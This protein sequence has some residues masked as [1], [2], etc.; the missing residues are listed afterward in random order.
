MLNP[1][2]FGG[3]IR[4]KDLNKFQ[5]SK[6]WN[7]K[8]FVNLAATQIDINLKTLPTVLKDNFSGKQDRVPKQSLPIHPF[9]A[10][11]FQPEDGKPKFIWY[12]HSVVLMQLHGFNLLIDPMFGPDASPIGPFATKRFSN[13]TL[14]I[15]DTLP[16]IDAILLTHDHYDHLDYKSI[17]KLKPKVNIWLVALGIS[18]H[19]EKWEIPAQQVKEFDWW[20]AVEFQGIKLTFTPSRH[21]A[22]RGA[23]DRS[24]TLWGG[25][26]FQSNDHKI[27]WSGDGG[28]GNHFKA[29]GQEY[30]P[31]DLAFVECG[32][33]YKHW[34][35][36]HLYPEESI[37]AAMDAQAQ[38]AVPVHWGAFTL[39]PHHWKDP[40]ERFVKEAIA[41]K[42]DY[43][44]PELGKI[45]T[46]ETLND[47]DNWWEKIK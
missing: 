47:M 6:N 32:Q 15:I 18:R 42:Q 26:I 1:A 46:F 30:G 28:Y 7:G 27:Y 43:F 22:G 20:E 34:H 35:Q 44:I 37:Q 21:F 2:Q 19:L 4:R 13:N 11:K 17:M 5:Q 9:D 29:I 45:F 10:E 23:L 33:Y 36:V 40:V 16:P 3:S 39:S 8:K 31:F 14:D 41:Q 24:K 12:G 25:W 38:V